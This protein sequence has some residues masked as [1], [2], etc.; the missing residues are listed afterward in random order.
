MT[1]TATKN[2]DAQA[3]FY[4]A[5]ASAGYK[6]DSLDPQA[7]VELGVANLIAN[8]VFVGAAVFQSTV[9]IQSLKGTGTRNVVVDDNGVLSAP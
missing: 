5:M 8:P 3:A 6:A 7:S 1:I 4:A 9:T 2:G